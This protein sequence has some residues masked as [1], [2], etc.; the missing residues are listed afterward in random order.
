[1]LNTANFELCTESNITTHKNQR[2]LLMTMG[3]EYAKS[4]QS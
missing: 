2:T 3:K 1:M 4:L